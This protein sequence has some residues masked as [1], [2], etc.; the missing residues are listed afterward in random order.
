MSTQLISRLGKNNIKITYITLIC[1]FLKYLRMFRID[2]KLKLILSITILE[3]NKM[4]TF[5]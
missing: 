5:L 4:L 3:E 2:N 1:L